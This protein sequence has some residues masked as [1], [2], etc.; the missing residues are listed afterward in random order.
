MALDIIGSNETFDA[1]V[2]FANE[3]HTAGKDKAVARFE[4]PDAAG[5]GGIVN[6]TIR[7]GFF[8]RTM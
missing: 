6:R 2:K 5:L 8:R 4:K 1:F 7:P 3:Q